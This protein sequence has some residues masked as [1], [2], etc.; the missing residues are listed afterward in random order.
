[1]DV[2]HP[3]TMGLS[4]APLDD[5]LAPEPD[6]AQ[7]LGERA[8]LIA[9]HPGDVIAALPAGAAAVRE[10]A[11]CLRFRFDLSASNDSAL[12]MAAL[13]RACA[14][15]VCVLSGDPDPVLVAAV[16]CF[17]NRWRLADKI[18]RSVTAV[19]DPVPDYADEMAGQVD[20]FIARL[21]PLR[22][23]RRS[24]WGLART[25]ELFTPLPSAPLD[26]RRDPCMVRCERQ[27]FVKLPETGATIFSIRT[28][29]VPWSGLA[30]APRQAI[31][32]QIDRLSPPWRAYKSISGL[33]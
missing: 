23:F 20:R 25:A 3:L 12:V 33:P 7:V 2:S 11:A 29:M 18:G 19:H 13:G 16:L 24:N 27:S 9:E 22:L 1:M 21:R 26:P 5:W 14:E 6:D 17:P 30:A 31:L 10:L 28:D 32:A 4:P 15:D 8:R